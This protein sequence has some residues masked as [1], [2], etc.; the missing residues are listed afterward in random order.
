[1][2]TTELAATSTVGEEHRETFSPR[3][4][5]CRGGV[6]VVEKCIGW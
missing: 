2:G 1:M 6:S 5:T 4:R 3:L